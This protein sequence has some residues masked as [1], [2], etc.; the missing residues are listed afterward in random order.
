[1]GVQARADDRA[2]E[3]G[4]LLVGKEKELATKV[5]SVDHLEKGHST[6]AA[7]RLPMGASSL[8]A[9][10]CIGPVIAR[11]VAL[12]Q[13]DQ[14]ALAFAASFGVRM[15]ALAFA[16]SFGVRMAAFAFAAIFRARMAALAFAASFRA[17]M[18][19][20]VFAASFRARMTVIVAFSRRGVVGCDDIV[21][22]V[23]IKSERT[24]KSAGTMI[25]P[26][27]LGREE[28]TVCELWIC[29]V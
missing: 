10:R 9:E 4:Q 17:R 24:T 29:R 5:S 7:S 6:L 25:S 15:A 2:V 1:M 16:A 8:R 22:V 13:L 23:R 3:N 26:G 28:M 19:A 21:V 12:V 27:K 18:A 20:L 14:A 11:L